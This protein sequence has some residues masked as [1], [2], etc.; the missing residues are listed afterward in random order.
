MSQ[1]SDEILLAWRLQDELDKL[2]FLRSGQALSP[3]KPE[4]REEIL[5]KE[6]IKELGF[7]PKSEDSFR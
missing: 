1:R 3:D 2:R 5:I 7:Q 4:H 6:R